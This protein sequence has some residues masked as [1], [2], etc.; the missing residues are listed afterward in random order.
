MAIVS[1]PANQKYRDNWSRIFKKKNK[2][3]RSQV[4]SI[5]A[6]IYL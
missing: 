5:D 1:R 2:K 6:G 4:T 3:I